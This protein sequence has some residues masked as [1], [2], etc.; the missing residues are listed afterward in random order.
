MGSLG[1]EMP[2]AF[3]VPPVEYVS[4]AAERGIGLVLEFA[5]PH[6][7]NNLQAALAALRH[8]ARPNAQLVIDAMHF[9]RSG[10][11]VADLAALAPGVVGHVQL[12]DVPLARAVDATRGLLRRSEV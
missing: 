11:T 5:S 7:I 10:A 9:F 6:P 3:G 1:I 2:S 4:M 12:C 8:I